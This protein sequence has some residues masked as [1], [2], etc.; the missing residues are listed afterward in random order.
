MN[1]S[2][3][4]RGYKRGREKKKQV[5]LSNTEEPQRRGIYTHIYI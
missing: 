1:Y 2:E 3:K 5:L 4:N